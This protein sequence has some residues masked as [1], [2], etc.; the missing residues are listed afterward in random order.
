MQKFREIFGENNNIEISVL[1]I[2]EV[3]KTYVLVSFLSTLLK[4][5]KNRVIMD[6]ESKMNTQSL[7][8][9]NRYYPYL[10]K[11]ILDLKVNK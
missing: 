7:N 10:M 2:K 6:K 5:Y 9:I 11:N 1:K 8:G 3:K 4:T